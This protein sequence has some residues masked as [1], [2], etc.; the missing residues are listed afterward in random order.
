LVYW[1]MMDVS[2]QEG[3]PGLGCFQNYV[4][5]RCNPLLSY[6]ATDPS[7]VVKFLRNI[8]ECILAGAAKPCNLA[9]LSSLWIR[10]GMKPSTSSA[11]TWG[12]HSRVQV[13]SQVARAFMAAVA[14]GTIKRV[15]WLQNNISPSHPWS[16]QQLLFMWYW[17]PK[18]AQL[19]IQT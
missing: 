8:V 5:N 18:F 16:S 10:H 2:L 19:G 11:C 12:G 1:V 15:P 6:P 7:C 4:H 17:L 9:L 14:P 13:P 3:D